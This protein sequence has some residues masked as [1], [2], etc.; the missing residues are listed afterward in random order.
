MISPTEIL[1]RYRLSWAYKTF[2]F[3]GNIGHDKYIKCFTKNKNPG[4]N[5][6]STH[7]APIIQKSTQVSVVESFLISPSNTPNPADKYV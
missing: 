7:R 5:S 6:A 1:V 3:V 4:K 2:G